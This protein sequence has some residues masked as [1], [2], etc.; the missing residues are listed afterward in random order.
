MAAARWKIAD[1]TIEFSPGALI[2]GVLNV[3]P[4]SFSDAGE[5]YD[6]D[7][8]V[9]HGLQ[10]SRDGAAILDIGGEST[11]PGSESV[12]E[13]EELRRV[14]PVIR[15]LRSATEA[16]ISID[17]AKASVARAAWDAGASIINDISGGRADDA[18]M[19]LAGES[20]CGF[21]IMHMQGTPRTMQKAPHYDDVVREVGEFFRQQYTRALECG[22][23]PMA[24]AFDPGIGFGKTLEHNLE[25]LRNLP[26]LRVDDRPLVVG[27]SRKSFL[28]K[29]TGS[30]DISDRIAPTIAMTALLRERGA[31][32][33]RVHDVK[34][35]T[36]G[37]RATEALLEDAR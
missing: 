16:L 28:G 15:R 37:L 36:L 23:E 10:M 18:M 14:L 25:L 27:V 26:R 3:T 35:N 5:F 24:I 20:G 33:L 12:A 17:T 19:P 29:V 2:M 6:T 34:P 13:D 21:I 4:D 8:A 7:K 11:R 9:E 31:D 22:I 32:V 1:Q 30:S